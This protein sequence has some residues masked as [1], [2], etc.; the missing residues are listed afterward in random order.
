[1]VVLSVATTFQLAAAEMTTVAGTGICFDGNVLVVTVFRA[2]WPVLLKLP[3]ITGDVGEERRKR[4]V[5]K[6]VPGY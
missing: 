5:L 2:D 4:L 1:V 3:Y 6:P